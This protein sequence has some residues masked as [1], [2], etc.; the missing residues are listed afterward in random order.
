[1]KILSVCVSKGGTGKTTTAAALAQAAVYRG[2]KVLAVDLDPQ[3]NLTLALGCRPNNY[4]L[5]SYNLIT[6][7]YD[8]TDVITESPL[9]IDVIGAVWDL[10]TITSAHGSA[11]RLKEALE[12]IKKN[13]DVIVIDTPTTAELQ[14]NAICAATDIII[15]LQTDSYNIQSLYQVTDII[16]ALREN[17]RGLSTGAIITRYDKRSN[18]SKKMRDIISNQ[19]KELKVK[20]YGE[21]RQAVA[22]AEAATFSRSLYAKKKLSAAAEDYLAL[23]DQIIK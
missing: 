9:D 3:G 16:K 12:P 15:P 10:A 23:F 5:N 21:I 20:Y 11:Q 19:A 14:Y 17:R 2:K 22:I 1:M 8:A 13:Y 7:K 18:H 4:D 6:G